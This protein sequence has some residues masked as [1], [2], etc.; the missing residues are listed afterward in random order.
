MPSPRFDVCFAMGHTGIDTALIISVG[1]SLYTDVEASL[2]IVTNPGTDY[3]QCN[4]PRKLSS[5]RSRYVDFM[6]RITRF[7]R[8]PAT[9]VFTFMISTELRNKKPNA[10]PV[11]CFPYDGLKENDLRRLITQLIKEMVAHGMKV[12]G[13]Y[14]YINYKM[15]RFVF[16][17]MQALSVMVSSII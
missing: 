8:T 3:Q 16:K 7:K 13:S 12:A 5:I 15:Q 9:H 14:M 6:K 4:I 2:G 1:R 17:H 11:Q 10:L